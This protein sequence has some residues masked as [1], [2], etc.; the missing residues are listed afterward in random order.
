MFRC[1][2]YVKDKIKYVSDIKSWNEAEYWQIEQE[3]MMKGTGDCEDMSILLYSLATKAGIPNWRIKLCA[4]NVMN[5]SN[6]KNVG[7]AYIIFLRNDMTWTVCDCCYYPTTFR[8]ENRVQHK[9]NQYYRDIWFTCNSEN[10]W[11]QHDVNV[12]FG[13]L[14]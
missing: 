14:K 6:G 13:G 7:H 5:P 1:E 12:T 8:L 3:T 4:G 10:A 11:A 9:D 2:Q